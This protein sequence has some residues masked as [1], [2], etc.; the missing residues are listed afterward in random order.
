MKKLKPAGYYVRINVEKVGKEIKK[1]ALT[2]FKLESN[3]TQKRLEDG[4]DV[5]I[6]EALGPTAFC[7]FQGIDD[8]QDAE[9][10]AKQYGV[11]LGKP[12]QFNRYDGKVPRHMEEGNYRII[13]DQHIIGM[14]EDDK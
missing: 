12:V 5:G 13:Q 1:G 9:A 6:L 2:G 8:E 10:R 11:E 4:H 7:G 14:Y 3:E